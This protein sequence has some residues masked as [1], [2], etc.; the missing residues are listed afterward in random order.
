MSVIFTNRVAVVSGGATGIGHAISKALSDAGV[1]VYVLDIHPDTEQ[2]SQAINTTGFVCNI[3][4]ANSVQSTIATILQQSHKIDILVNNA[5]VAHL[6]PAEQVSNEQWDITM[7]MNV[8]SHF[9][10]SQLIIPQMKKQRYGRIVSISSQASL[11]ALEQHAA[12]CASKAAL[13]ALTRVLALELGPYQITA[14]TVAP[15]IIMTELGKKAWAGEKGE[16]MKHKI[17]VQHFGE[18][19]DVAR[20]VLFL[21]SDTASLIN[22]HTL[23]VDGG[24]SIQ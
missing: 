9:Q 4:D 1:T 8:K 7:N 15:T 11:I 23:V 13:D 16:Q 2:I 6:A 22:G 17:P 21:A 5:G 19:E 12:Y 18:P 20:A 10:M 24:Y 3:L 14:N